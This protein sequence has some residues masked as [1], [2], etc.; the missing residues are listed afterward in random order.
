MDD[1]IQNELE[2]KAKSNWLRAF[3]R[4][5]TRARNQSEKIKKNE[6]IE[7]FHDTMERPIGK[8]DLNF[9]GGCYLKLSEDQPPKIG[10][11]VDWEK[12]Y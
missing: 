11:H 4:H 2:Q 9:S 8:Y 10:W 3:D 6:A 1:A 5:E 12:I 7:C